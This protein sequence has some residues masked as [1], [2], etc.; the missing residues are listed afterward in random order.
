MLKGS[1]GTSMLERS[2]FMRNSKYNIGGNL[3]SLF[4]VSACVWQLL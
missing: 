1:P 2:S 4:E 3:F